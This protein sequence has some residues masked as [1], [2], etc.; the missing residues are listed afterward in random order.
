MNK[1]RL[2]TLL[3]FG[4]GLIYILWPTPSLDKN[5]PPLPQSLKSDEPGDTTQ[6]KNVAAYFS[7]YRR[8]EAVKF[9]KDQFSYLNI[10]G[11]TIPPIRLNHPPEE[12]FT[13]IR[14]QQP[15]TFLE[16][17]TYPLRD[18]LFVN[19]FEPFDEKGKPYRDGATDIYV[20]GSFYETKTTLR[21]FGSS[22][23]TRL[24]IYILIWICLIALLKLSRKATIEK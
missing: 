15:S 21:Y 6:V 7:N 10:F 22:A 13:Y 2:I 11:F 18:S 17:Y 12:A 3:F 19:G 14:D 4:L 24:V 8:S 9:Y 20:N 23:A 16:Q 5:I 1:K